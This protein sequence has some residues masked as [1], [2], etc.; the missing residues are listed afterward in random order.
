MK[1]IRSLG[2]AALISV[3]SFSAYAKD[4]GHFDNTLTKDWN[5]YREKLF[6]HGVNLK[7]SYKLDAFNN[8]DGGITSGEAILDRVVT[9]LVFDGEKI[10]NIKGLT[11][12]VTYFNN[13]GGYP[14]TYVGSAQGTDAMEVKKNKSRFYE[15]W[16]QQNFLD[17]KVSALVGLLDINNEFF[18]ADS[19]GMF[20]HQIDGIGIGSKST[21]DLG[22]YSNT[23]LRIRVSPTKEYYI[24]AALADHAVNHPDFPTNHY[25]KVAEVGYTPTFNS[26]PQKF[27][28]GYWGYEDNNKEFT[29]AKKQRN[30]G[31][32]LVLENRLYECQDK[33]QSL[34]SF[35]RINMSSPSVSR[36][37]KT[38]NIGLVYKGLIPNRSESKLGFGVTSSHQG[39]SY[40]KEKN[41]GANHYSTTET[42]YELSYSDDLLPWL[43]VQPDLQYVVN[44][45]GLA[46]IKDDATV[47]GVRFIARI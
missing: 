22:G 10:L 40:L 28:I 1:V 3:C 29:S 24:Q 30:Q 32:Y 8:I 44:P 33:N 12:N 41:V 39:K 27:A 46:N 47:I 42:V 45:V 9:N 18:H 26:L 17:N 7:L 14:D 2:L 5:G 16:I 13:S 23:T 36:F 6:N 37:D 11:A 15:A 31:G 34:T 20:I 38:F 21:F 43:T 4:G 19:T 25:L 35:V